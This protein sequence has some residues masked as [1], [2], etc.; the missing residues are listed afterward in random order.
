MMKRKGIWAGIAVLIVGLIYFFF[1]PSSNALFPKCPFLVL[2]GLKCPGCGS[3]RVIHNLLHFNVIEAARLNLLLVLSL[4]IVAFLLYVEAKRR[5]KPD[6]YTKVHRIKY[7]WI[8]FG[9]VIAW[10]IGR[11]IPDI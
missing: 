8:Y 5:T 11:N 3:Q 7:I 1:N 10:W 2:T 4:P 9:I 6:L